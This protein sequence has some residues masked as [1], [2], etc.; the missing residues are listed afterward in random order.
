MR[1]ALLSLKGSL[2]GSRDKELEHWEKSRLSTSATGAEIIFKVDR[3][4][5]GRILEFSPPRPTQKAKLNSRGL[6]K[7]I[8]KIFSPVEGARYSFRICRCALMTRGFLICKACLSQP[9]NSEIDITFQLLKPQS[10]S[11]HSLFSI[12]CPSLENGCR[13]L[14]PAAAQGDCG[15]GP[16]HVKIFQGR[17]REAEQVYFCNPIS[18]WSDDDYPSCDGAKRQAYLCT[19]W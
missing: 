8:P 5:S 3:I 15:T 9:S 10:V 17:F 13:L 6:R 4:G 1:A 14:L 7:I 12:R 18:D 16:P 11:G 19:G 2:G